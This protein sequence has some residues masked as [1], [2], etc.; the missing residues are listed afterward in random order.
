[1][2]TV[3]PP[4]DDSSDEEDS[5]EIKELSDIISDYK[6]QNPIGNENELIDY[7]RKIHSKEVIKQIENLTK[8]QTDSAMW[9]KYRKGRITASVMGSVYKCRIE[10][11]ATENYIVKKIFGSSSFSSAATEYGKAMESV[12]LQQYFF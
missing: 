5:L 8:D 7:L 9:Y 12:A 10:N 3:D 11:L 6:Q 1:M 2:H 4:S